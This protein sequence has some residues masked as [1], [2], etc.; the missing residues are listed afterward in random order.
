MVRKPE[1][2]ELH[3]PRRKV[4]RLQ[5]VMPRVPSPVDSFAKA[6]ASMMFLQKPKSLALLNWI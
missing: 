2:Q 1:M 6:A 4:E 3:T 5:T